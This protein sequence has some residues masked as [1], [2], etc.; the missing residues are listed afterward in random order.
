MIFKNKPFARFA[1]KEGI[2][3]TA[4]CIAIE[5]A[6]QGQIDADLGGGVIK[7]RIA[8]T[9]G[10]KSGGYRSIV[11]FRQQNHSFFVYGFAKSSRSNISTKEL[12]AFKELATKL[13]AFTEEDLEKAVKSVA[14][15]RVIC[16]H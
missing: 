16:D 13:L 6:E 15:V 1:E 3:D 7:Q 14:L 9:G 2:T 11:V 5:Q 12:S 10:G 4:L 8:R